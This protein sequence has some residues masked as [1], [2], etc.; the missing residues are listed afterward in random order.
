MPIIQSALV[1]VDVYEVPSI[2][3]TLVDVD[4]YEVPSMNQH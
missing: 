3:S 4:M 2:A 1:D